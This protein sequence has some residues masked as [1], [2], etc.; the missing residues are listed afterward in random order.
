MHSAT[1]HTVVYGIN[2]LYEAL[3][4]SKI[5]SLHI[6]V[7]GSATHQACYNLSAIVLVDEPST[8]Q[9]GAETWTVKALRLETPRVSS[10]P[11]LDG[12]AG[13][14]CPKTSLKPR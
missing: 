5:Y 12:H 11:Q 14:P 13:A 9:L 1:A 3:V 2:S 6:L 10:T 7:V 4:D 8:G